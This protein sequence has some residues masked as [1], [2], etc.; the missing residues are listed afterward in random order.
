M[1]FRNRF[2]VSYDV[3]KTPL[4]PTLHTEIFSPLNAHKQGPFDEFRLGTKFRY[5]INNRHRFDAGI[6]YIHEQFETGVSGIIF[7]LGYKIS[8]G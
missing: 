1:H 7:Q 6:V 5:P 8:V 3:P 4:E 2:S